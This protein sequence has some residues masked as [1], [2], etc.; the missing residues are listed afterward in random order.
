MQLNGRIAPCLWFDT[1]GEDAARF[2]IGIFPNSRIN[3]IA[4]YGHEGHAFH[5][6]QPGDVMT[7]PFELNGQNFTALNG[8]PGFKFNEAVSLQI[9]CDS[10]Q[11]IDHDWNHLTPGGDDTTQQCGWLKDR[12]GVS[13][14]MM[15]I[16]MNEWFSGQS[17]E[18][19]ERTMKAM[20]TMK[21]LDI[22]ALRRAHEGQTPA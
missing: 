15:P 9:D 6:K 17:S 19:S 21:Q 22:A 10:Q 18:K 11:E 14:Q 4:R 13:W 20:L 5:H 12:F 7:V 2:Y 8:G 16:S 3:S 1:Q